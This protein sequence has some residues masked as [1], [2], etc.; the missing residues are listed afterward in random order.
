[1]TRLLPLFPLDIVLFPKMV[2]PL[3]IF[4][5]RYKEMIGECLRSKS[6]FGVLYTHEGT[7]A[8]V[9]CLAGILR[10]LK[11]YDDGRMDLLAQGGDR[12]EILHF[13]TS[14]SYLQ[15][16]SESFADREEAQPPDRKAVQQL[17]DLFQETARILKRSEAEK[18][19]VSPGYQGLSFQIAAG[20]ALPKTVKQRVLEGRSETERVAVLIAYFNENLPRLRRTGVA[21]KRAGSNGHVR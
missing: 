7:T 17:L 10:V 6:P 9:G 12:F 19:V 8:R 15:G 1:M 20:F 13:D 11:K 2:L 4:E 14:A 16:W 21:V 5:E 3:H 18:V